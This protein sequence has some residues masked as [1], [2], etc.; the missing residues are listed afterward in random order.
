MLRGSLKTIVNRK[1]GFSNAMSL[2]SSARKLDGQ[3]FD[4]ILIANRGEI[5]CRITRTA[6]RMGIKTVAVFSDADRYAEHVRLADEAVYI[7]PAPAAESYLVGEKIIKACKDTGAQAVHPGYGFLSENLGF[8]KLCTDNNVVFIGPPPAAIKAM[9]SKSES[10]DIMIKAKVPV[11][12]GYHGDDN[13]NETLLQKAREIGF[14]LMIKAVSG[15]GG[16][17]MRLVHEESKFLE[18]LESCRREAAKSFKDDKVLI[19]KLV[20]S[21]RHV[22]LQVFGDHHGNAVHLMER[23][24]SIQR[25][26]QK[27]FEEAPAPNLTPEQR[28][29]MGDAA[30]ACVKATGYV[31]AGTVEFLIDTVSNDFYFCEMNTRLQVEHPVTELITGTDL[32]E[33]QLRVASGQKIPLTQEEIFARVKGCAIEARIY[34]EN[35]LRDFLPASGYLAHLQTPMEGRNGEPGIRVDSGVIAGNTVSTF[36]DPMIAKLIVYDEN[37]EK[38]LEK[39]ERS[40]RSYQVAGPAN[41]IDFLTKVA[42]HPGFTKEQPTTAFFDKHM[43]GILESL[44][45]TPIQQLPTHALVGLVGYYESL[46]PSVERKS[47]WEGAGEFSNWR[48]NR[49]LHKS[50]KATVQKDAHQ[51]DF[52][53]K[54]G[55]EFTFRAHEKH[56]H[57]KNAKLVRSKVVARRTSPTNTAVTVLE[58]TTE[59]EDN[60]VTGTTVVQVPADDSDATIDVW[61]DGQVTDHPTHYSFKVSQKT[62]EIGTASGSSNPVVTSPMPGKIAKV[63][64][65][66]GAMVKKGDLLVTLEAM[67]MEHN[68]YAPCDGKVSIFCSEGSPVGEGTKLAEV[69]VEN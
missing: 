53:V 32:V 15:G 40:L 29:A 11:T 64:V 35:P 41:N 27:V 19:E 65:A 55:N 31:G 56:S 58:T 38:A 13:S 23:D 33:W 24:C 17:G 68:L 69:T 2:S 5:A 48:S 8:C 37:R 10:K 12:P 34:A 9:G 22:E 61:I 46:N 45:P 59:I 39:M 43:T 21:P 6:K 42:R 67:K 20:R 16:K 4:K 60:L 3:L 7:G 14:P 54:T 28:K 26:H 25:R 49:T 47:I 57:S 66:E 50:V 30:V 51:I 18:S 63:L 52:E 62:M 36:Y 44:E 1:F